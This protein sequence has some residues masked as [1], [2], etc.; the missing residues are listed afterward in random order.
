M[1]VAALFALTTVRQG[2]NVPFKLLSYAVAKSPHPL[3]AKLV[4]T[5]RGAY[6]FLLLVRDPNDKTRSIVKLNWRHNNVLAVFPGLVQK[7][8]KIKVKSVKH[9]GHTFSVSLD[10]HRGISSISYY[11]VLLFTIPKQP[12]QLDLQVL[13]PSQHR[14]EARR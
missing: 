7:D 9:W 6:D 11:P 10:K 4:R 13:D 14:Y 5:K 3:E 12:A 1:L 8:A 2:A